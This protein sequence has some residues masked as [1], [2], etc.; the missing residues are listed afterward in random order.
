MLERERVPC[1]ASAWMGVGGPGRILED[2]LI[3][4]GLVSEPL[5]PGSGLDETLSPEA[6]L[7][8]S[9]PQTLEAF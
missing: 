8:T 1:D 4:P 9:E 7:Q 6:R 3:F 2:S 5:S